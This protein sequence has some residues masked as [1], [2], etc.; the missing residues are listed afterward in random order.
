MNIAL[1][2]IGG[3]LAIAAVFIFIAFYKWIRP[4]WCAEKFMREK[5]DAAKNAKERAAII[6]EVR[7][8][9]VW[10]TSSVMFILGLLL[11]II[12]IILIF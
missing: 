1:I 9:F 2:I 8:V 4:E 7:Q 6:R 12:G 10:M 11:I 5:Y 3:I